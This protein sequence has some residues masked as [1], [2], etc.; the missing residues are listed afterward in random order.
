MLPRHA[1]AAQ[2]SRS[3]VHYIVGLARNAR[4]EAQVSETLDEL[5]PADVFARRLAQE[6]LADELQAALTERY[7]SIVADLQDAAQ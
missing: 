2:Q 4:L 7:T 6:E 3:G 5:T 1:K